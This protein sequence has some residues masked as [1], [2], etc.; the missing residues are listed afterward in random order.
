[1]AE[2][3]R[4]DEWIVVVTACVASCSARRRWL[5]DDVQQARELDAHM[6]LLMQP[7]SLQSVGPTVPRTRVCAGPD[8]APPS[9]CWPTTVRWVGSGSFCL[10]RVRQ[11]RTVCCARRPAEALLHAGGEEQ[12]ARLLAFDALLHLHR[13]APLSS[14]LEFADGQRLALASLSALEFPGDQ[15]LLRGVLL[16]GDEST[17]SSRAWLSL[18]R[19]LGLCDLRQLWIPATPVKEAEFPAL[20][21]EL[22]NTGDTQVLC[23]M[24]GASDLAQEERN[25]R[26]RSGIQHMADLGSYYDKQEQADPA[27]RSY[28]RGLDLC[29]RRGSSD[30][31]GRLL[32]A[33]ARSAVRG[34]ASSGSPGRT[35]SSAQ[36]DSGRQL[37]QPDVGATPLLSGGSG[38]R[39]LTCG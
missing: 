1:M 8:Q 29:L 28:R 9:G 12:E 30:V 25:Q 38:G 16:E 31:A 3:G 19:L 32:V 24:L 11:Y 7:D 6:L 15:L 13:G 22:L 34:H 26:L 14:W 20:A 18:E 23:Y 21:L 10:A 37:R 36:A 2:P 4:T 39:E 5:G 17:D 27:W 33:A 35:A